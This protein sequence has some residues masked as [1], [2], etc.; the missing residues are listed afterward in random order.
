MGCLR[1]FEPAGI[2]RKAPI[3]SAADKVRAS[4]GAGWN[5]PDGLND[6]YLQTGLVPL[7]GTAW[8]LLSG[9]LGLAALRKKIF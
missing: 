3:V 2:F 4:E 7:P 1:K 8:L 9:L 5:T 6:T